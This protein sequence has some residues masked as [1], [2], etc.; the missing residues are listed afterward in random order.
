MSMK[1]RVVVAHVLLSSTIFFCGICSLGSNSTAF[2]KD[3]TPSCELLSRGPNI[4]ESHLPPRLFTFLN[5]FKK[6]LKAK[7]W[8]SF[9]SYFHERSQARKDIGNQIDAILR[10]RYEK[11]WD[12]TLF[13]L[14]KL[15]DEQ[16]RKMVFECPL[17]PVAGIVSRFGYKDQYFAIFQV[18]GQNE[19]GRLLVSVAP[20]KNSELKIIGFHIQQW[21]HLGFDWQYWTQLGNQYLASNQNYRAYMAYDTAE[22]LLMSGDFISHQL[23]QDIIREKQKIYSEEE[24]LRKVIDDSK[25]TDIVYASRLLHKKG[26]GL[27]VRVALEKELNSEDLINRCKD[28]GRQLKQSQLIYSKTGGV[29]CNFIPKGTDP[30]KDSIIGGYYISAEDLT[31]STL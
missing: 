14:W 17:S 24:F 15:Q 30:K 21:T 16:A 28:I 31:K 11:P 20:N 13:R 12:I 2:A 6:D 1:Q 23:K 8:Y 22:L 27:F 3:I 5:E 7:R 10:N 19:L 9:R 29:K 26:T 18:M 25:R 4:I